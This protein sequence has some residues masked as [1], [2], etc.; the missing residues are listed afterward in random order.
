MDMCVTHYT[1]GYKTH[2]LQFVEMLEW[3]KIY[4]VSILAIFKEP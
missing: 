2:S 1:Y 3:V 4:F